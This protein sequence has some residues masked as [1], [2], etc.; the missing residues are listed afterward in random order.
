MSCGGSGVVRLWNTVYSC[1]VGQF[2]AHNG[3]LGSIVMTVSPCGKYLATADREGTLKIWDIQVGVYIERQLQ[4]T[5][6]IH[7]ETTCY[8]DIC[9]NSSRDRVTK[10][11]RVMQ[12]GGH[13]TRGRDRD[14]QAGCIRQ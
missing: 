12:T 4:W 1:L 11:E 8:H 13:R 2:T 10:T 5:T 3:D 14:Q 9:V 6:L 7:N